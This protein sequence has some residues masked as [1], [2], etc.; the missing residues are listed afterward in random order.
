MLTS[1][2][3]VSLLL[4]IAAASLGGIVA[5]K[6]KVQPL[7]GYIVSGVVLGSLLPVTTDISKLAELGIILLL[8]S[9]GLEF[10]VTK[11]IKVFKNIFWAVLIQAV[12]ITSLASLFL[13]KVGFEIVPAVIIGFGIF[14]S[15]TAVVVKILSDRGETETLHGITMTGWLLIQDLMVVPAVVLISSFSFSSIFKAAYVIITTVIFGRLI[16]PYL[17]HK[18]ASFNSRELLV[19][20]SLTFAVGVA[21]LTYRLGISP[22]LGAFLA[23]LVLAESSEKHAVFAEIRPL[24]DVFVAVFFVTL[25]FM[26][27][28][29]IL[30]GHFFLILGLALFMILAKTLCDFV[31]AQIVGFRGKMSVAIALGLSQVGE[32]SFVILSLATSLKFIKQEDA[33][34]TIASA[35]I[36]LLITP[37]LFKSIIP[38]WKRLKQITLKVPWLNRYFVGSDRH[39][40]ERVEYRNHIIICGYGRVGGWVGRALNDVGTPFVIIEYNQAIVSD[41][42]KKGF[43]VIYGDPGESE[44][45]DAAG[46]KNAKVVVLAIPDRISQEMLIGHVQTVAPKV[47]IISRVH[48]DEDWERLKLMKIH[49]VVQ[50]EFEAAIAI[51]RTLLV[52]MGKSKE[53]IAQRVRSLRISRSQKIR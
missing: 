41:L 49:K 3:S 38:V 2:F 42:K 13:L 12:L 14:Y 50:P 22:A 45:L 24:K 34:L 21:Y 44:V 15:S 20:S 48:L 43:P 53:E 11:I 47:K 23:G 1:V 4:A 52:S 17:I 18:I 7:I 46:I 39:L 37:F 16:V 29:A 31:I 5:K 8:F 26:V 25:G 19:L 35:L 6:L 30:F 10:P 36:T 27:K 51:T 33:S 28:P 32:F 9:L 40:S